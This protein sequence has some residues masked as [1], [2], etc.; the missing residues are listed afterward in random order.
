MFTHS[1]QCPSYL[2]TVQQHLY[3][4]A[5]TDFLFTKMS[6]SFEQGT[7]GHL[8]TISTPPKCL[9]ANSYCKKFR[10]H[11]DSKELRAVKVNSI[12]FS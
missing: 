4:V 1:A 6:F 8:L 12:D 3:S 11:V 9:P 5:D 7:E 2:L 10:S